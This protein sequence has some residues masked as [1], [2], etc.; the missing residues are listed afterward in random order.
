MRRKSVNN[1]I[2]E[3]DQ[4]L[5][6][7]EGPCITLTWPGFYDL[8]ERERLKQPFLDNVQ[9]AAS[10]RFQLIVAFGYNAVIVC[11][12]RNFANVPSEKIFPQRSVTDIVQEFNDFMRRASQSYMTLRWPE[13]YELCGRERLKQRFLDGVREVA[14]EHFQLIVAYG[15]NAIVVCHDR[16]FADITAEQ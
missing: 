12:D 7:A 2:G 16:N 13:F 8:C 3:I 1:I 15:H 6:K 10:T 11:P 9:E 14:S 4:E 5:R